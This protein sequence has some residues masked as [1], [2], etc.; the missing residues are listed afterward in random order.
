MKQD[1]ALKDQL[2]IGGQAS[3]IAYSEGTGLLRLLGKVYIRIASWLSF[4]Y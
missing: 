4:A 2:R 3:V 1:E